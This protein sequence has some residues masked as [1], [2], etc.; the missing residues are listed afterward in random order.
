M[1]YVYFHIVIKKHRNVG[2]CKH[3][4]NVYLPLRAGCSA[5]LWAEAVLGGRGGKL[6]DSKSRAGAHLSLQQN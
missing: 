1:I 5:G 2:S 6:D 4:F 3:L